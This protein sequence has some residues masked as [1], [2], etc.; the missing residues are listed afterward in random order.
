MGVTVAN[1]VPHSSFKTSLI[2]PDLLFL[3]EIIS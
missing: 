2:I 1:T 3:K